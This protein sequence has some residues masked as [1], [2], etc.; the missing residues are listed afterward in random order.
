MRQALVRRRADELVIFGEHF[1]PQLQ[2]F[3]RMIEIADVLRRKGQND[4]IGLKLGP[5]R[6]VMANRILPIL[7]LCRAFNVMG[8]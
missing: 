1:V 5:R 4:S 8:A 7:Q 2:H 6:P 3:I